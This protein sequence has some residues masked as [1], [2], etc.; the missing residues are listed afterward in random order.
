MQ[1]EVS[2]YTGDRWAAGT[3]ADVSIQLFGSDG[4]SETVPL[5]HSNN[6]VKFARNQVPI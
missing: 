6:K 3:D 2:V 5:L 4:N 1:Y